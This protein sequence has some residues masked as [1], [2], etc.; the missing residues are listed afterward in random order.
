MI[1]DI[2]VILM[3]AFGLFAILMFI[4]FYVY[5]K[6][7]YNKK[8]IFDDYTKDVNYYKEEKESNNEKKNEYEEFIPKKKK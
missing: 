1:E 8:H 5:L 7:R 2:L 6:K 3:M 4:L